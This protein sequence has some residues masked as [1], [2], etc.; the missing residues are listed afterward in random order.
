MLDKWSKLIKSHELQFLTLKGFFFFSEVFEI[1]NEMD[2]L[3]GVFQR[4]SLVHKVFSIILHN[5]DR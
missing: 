2:F 1:T 3:T 5:T 4:P